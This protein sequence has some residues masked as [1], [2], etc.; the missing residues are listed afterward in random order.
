MYFGRI[1]NKMS[2][3]I[4]PMRYLLLIVF[5]LLCIIP[6]EGSQRDLSASEVTIDSPTAEIHQI[7]DSQKEKKIDLKDPNTLSII[8][9]AASLSGVLLIAIPYLS[10]IGLILGLG[11]LVL[12]WMMRKKVKKKIWAKLAILLGGLCLAFFLAT[13]YLVM[14]F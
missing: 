11:G 7:I 12:G 2:Y 4:D 3:F 6:V 8:A 1:K 10:L 9:F 5:I 14:F 13:V